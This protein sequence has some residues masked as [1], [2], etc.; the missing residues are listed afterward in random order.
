[1]A[2][3]AV[4]TSGDVGLHKGKCANQRLDH[5]HIL[6]GSVT[7]SYIFSLPTTLLF[8]TMSGKRAPMIGDAGIYLP[9]WPFYLLR[10]LLRSALE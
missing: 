3:K 10:Q 4:T 2:E 6:Y 1:M 7:E 8:W 9:L 5:L